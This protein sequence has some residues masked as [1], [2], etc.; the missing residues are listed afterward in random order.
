VAIA[1][2]KTAVAQY[3]WF[4]KSQ[5]KRRTTIGTAAIRATVS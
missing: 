1:T 2:T 5:A 4:G 3:A